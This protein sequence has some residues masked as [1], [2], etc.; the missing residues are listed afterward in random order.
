MLPIAGFVLTVAVAG[1]SRGSSIPVQL[2][3]IAQMA[4]VSAASCIAQGRSVNVAGAVIAK[5]DIPTYSEVAAFFYTIGK[6][7]YGSRE[8]QVGYGLARIAPLKRGQS[9]TFR[10]T[11]TSSRAPARCYVVWGGRRK[12]PQGVPTPTSAPPAP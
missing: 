4:K 9:R 3:G 12:V 10:I 8:E 1:S 6:E 11:A 2:T 7:H 5:A